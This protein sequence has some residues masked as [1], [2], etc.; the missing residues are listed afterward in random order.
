MVFPYLLFCPQQVLRRWCYN[1]EKKKTADAAITY[2][3]LFEMLL[4]IRLFGS[5]QRFYILF[6]I[7]CSARKLAVRG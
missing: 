2:D 4:F 5:E 7:L 3:L 6:A 1:Y